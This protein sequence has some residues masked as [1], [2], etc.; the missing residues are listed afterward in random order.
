MKIRNQLLLGFAI[1][2][3]FTIYM[4]SRWV[5]ND[6]RPRYLEMMEEGLVDTANI[7]ALVVENQTL[8]KG[9]KQESLKNV[10]S[11]PS[12]RK[13]EACLLSSLVG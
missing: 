11:D 2:C 10:F 13:L 1:I 9:L 4:L 5:L 7:L 12:S 3:L 6:L 8:E